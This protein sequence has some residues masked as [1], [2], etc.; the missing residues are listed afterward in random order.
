[1][2]GE[3]AGRLRVAGAG[4]LR[5]GAADSAAR[6]GDQHEEDLRGVFEAPADQRSAGAR[7]GVGGSG[8]G[9]A[10]RVTAGRGGRRQGG[11]GLGRRP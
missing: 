9:D 11:A 5:A 1:M 2:A 8:G 3:R 7:S 6:A 4:P 10:V